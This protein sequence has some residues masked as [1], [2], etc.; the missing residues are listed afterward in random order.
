MYGN[1]VHYMKTVFNIWKLCS[2][3][4]N[5]VHYME[6]VFSIWKQCSL[7]IIWKQCSIYENSV[8]YMKTVFN[9]WKLCPVY[10]NCDQYMETVKGKERAKAHGENTNS[11][12]NLSDGFLQYPKMLTQRFLSNILSFPADMRRAFSLYGLKQEWFKGGLPFLIK[13]KP[14]AGTHC[15]EQFPNRRHQKFWSCDIWQGW[16]YIVLRSSIF[17][18][19]GL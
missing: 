1:C 8:Q 15:N 2:V 12:P 6:T 18:I 4:G 19:L 10:G 7:F 3:Y 11:F 9:I 17:L 14:T 16:W 13:C 5:S